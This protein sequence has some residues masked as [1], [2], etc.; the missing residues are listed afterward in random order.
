MKLFDERKR[1]DI[2]LVFQQNDN[3]STV[4]RQ[5][6]ESLKGIL[7]IDAHQ[8]SLLRAHLI[9]H[10]CVLCPQCCEHAIDKLQSRHE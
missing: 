9:G 8:L 3:S 6:I 4:V 10:C 7:S 2:C 1:N 5:E